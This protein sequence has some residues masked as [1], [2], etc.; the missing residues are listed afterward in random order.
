MLSMFVLRAL[1]DLLL[2]VFRRFGA[3]L[4]WLARQTGRQRAL[5]AA[6][7]PHLTG[8]LDVQAVVI[9]ADLAMIA[10]LLVAR[11]EPQ[12]WHVFLVLLV[13]VTT[14]V[15]ALLRP[16]RLAAGLILAGQAT[17]TVLTAQWLPTEWAALLVLPGFALTVQVLLGVIW[18][19]QGASWGAWFRA[20]A[21][22]LLLGVFSGV[23]T[24]LVGLF[25]PSFPLW[26]SALLLTA[27]AVMTVKLPRPAAPGSA[28]AHPTVIQGQIVPNQA[29]PPARTD[30]YTTYRPSSLD[31]QR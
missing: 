19:Q 13:L 14:T 21:A 6:A 16:G 25:A 5:G 31:D 15:A 9:A 8:L 7:T 27:A 3:G 17:W 26:I 1:A 11:T 22:G 18:A 10:G 30:S 12:L 4:G 24:A 29:L 2:R 23:A 28:V 20:T